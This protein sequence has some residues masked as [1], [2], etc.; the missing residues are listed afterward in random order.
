MTSTLTSISTRW[1]L[2]EEG[3][4]ACFAGCDYVAQYLRHL[5]QRRCAPRLRPDN[6]VSF[7]Y[8]SLNRCRR[9]APLALAGWVVTESVRAI[10]GFGLVTWAPTVY[11]DLMID[12]RTTLRDVAAQPRLSI[13]GAA[14]PAK[15]VKAGA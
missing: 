5:D 15:G 8:A 12:A 10:A 4:L 9:A 2:G 3:L 14:A 11:G 7:G 6:P 13:A 1:P